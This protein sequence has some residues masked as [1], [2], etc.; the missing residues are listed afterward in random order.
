MQDRNC[1]KSQI[2]ASSDAAES[3]SRCSRST[4]ALWVGNVTAVKLRE[5]GGR[6]EDKSR[7]LKARAL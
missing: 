4:T 6:S 5:K 1:H 7:L 3:K 2:D